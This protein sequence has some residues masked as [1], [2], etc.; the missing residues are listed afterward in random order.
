MLLERSRSGDDTGPWLTMQFSGFPRNAKPASPNRNN[1]LQT[2][3]FAYVEGLALDG[4][5]HRNAINGFIVSAKP[6]R[7]DREV[8]NVELVQGFGSVAHPSGMQLTLY[9]LVRGKQMTD[10]RV[11][12]D[13]RATPTVPHK[14]CEESSAPQGWIGCPWLNHDGTS[15][16]CWP[17]RN[18]IGHRRFAPVATRVRDHAGT[19]TRMP[20][21]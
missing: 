2:L 13:F 17:I 8:L 3:R 18:L 19:S 20:G 21:A 11:V 6:E 10:R 1:C 12:E 7:L 14:R 15:F 5:N 9:V 4:F 16:R